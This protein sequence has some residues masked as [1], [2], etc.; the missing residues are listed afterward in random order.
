METGDPGIALL[1]LYDAALPQVYGY[2]LSRC[3]RQPL[4]EDLT[5]EV[6]LAAVDAVRRDNP[7]T[8]TT[9]WLIGTARHKLVDH[10]RQAR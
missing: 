9:A 2:L 5:S 8:L 7:P 10:W 6:F 3:G 4:A 1:S